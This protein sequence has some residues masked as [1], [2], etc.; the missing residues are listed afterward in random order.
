MKNDDG[1]DEVYD[2]V[3]PVLNDET[4]AR[5]SLCIKSK[6]FQISSGGIADCKRHA[7]GK[8][9]MQLIKHRSK[10]KTLTGSSSNLSLSNVGLYEKDKVTKAE[11]L[12]ALNVVNCNISFA[13]A[14]GDTKRFQEMFPDS[15]IAKKYCQ[16]ETKTKY[17]IQ[18]GIA[19]HVKSKLLEDFA[20]SP[21]SFKFDETTTSQ[22][23]K[24]Y[25][26]Y[27]TYMSALNNKVVTAYAGS[28]FVGHCTSVD[29][30]DHFLA[31]IKDLNL[32][33]NLFMGIGMDGPNVN[34]KFERDLMKKLDSEKG[35][36]IIPIGNCPLHTVNNA[37][38]EGMKIIKAVLDIEQFLIDLHFFFK[39]SSARRED[40][41]E[42]EDLTDVTTEF[43]LRYC[44]TRWLYIGK[45][46]L[47]V[48]EQNENIKLY[49]LTKLP[50]LAGFKG[51][52][53]VG[54]T[55]RYQCIKKMLNNDLLLPCMS[56]VVYASLIFKPFVLLF[57]KEEPMIHMLLP[58][59]KKLIQDLLVKFVDQKV[60]KSKNLAGDVNAVLNYDVNI[61]ANFNVQRDMGTKT[62][63]LLTD[64]IVQEN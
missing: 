10:Q 43:M 53:G 12:Q 13:S 60:L 17:T 22:V 31:F 51:K 59:M 6:P 5:C 2:W 57:Q 27:I 52:K 30:L 32:D 7:K 46:V 49:F 18:F 47:R 42:I 4:K 39:L 37:F 33:T 45:T 48:M 56:F 36:S 63:S 25:D 35:N 15:E 40:Y 19:P 26:G 61:A 54:S 1:I 29:L 28:L 3:T 20:G 8:G 23:K 11:I 16:G 34:K 50:T 62:N 41:K 24:Q 44:S 38:G 58:Q 14:S 64:I 9:H 55:E 21:F